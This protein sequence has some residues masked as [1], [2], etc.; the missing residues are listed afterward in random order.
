MLYQ[1]KDA[2]YH[3][4]GGKYQQVALDSFNNA[5]NLNGEN[6]SLVVQVNQYKGGYLLL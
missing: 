4:G 6:V 2:L 5:L 1:A 3:Q